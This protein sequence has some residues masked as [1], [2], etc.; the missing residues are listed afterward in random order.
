MLKSFVFRVSLT[1]GLILLGA[2]G[3]SAQ[4]KKP[5][6]P[7]EKPAVAHTK[8]AGNAG[9]HGP[10]SPGKPAAGTTA[11]HS[12]ASAGGTHTGPTTN[13]T[14]THTGTTT[15]R[16]AA[17]GP[18]TA[19][20]S[21]TANRPAAGANTN[22]G[23]P[24]SGSTV[25][26][27]PGS[28]GRP[29]GPVHN[30]AVRPASYG[31]AGRPAPLGSHQQQLRNGNALQRRPNGRISDVHDARRGMEI[32]NSLNGG[33]R[34]VVERPDHSR[35]FAERGRPGYIQRPY[36]YQGHDF[37]RRSYYYHGH[38]YESYYR[39]YSYRG[40]V[41][42]VYAPVRYYPIGFY[43][44]A[45]HPWRAPIVFAWGWGG[46]PWYG[47]YGGYFAPYP[48]YATPAL[49]LT[50]YMISSELAAAYEAGRESAASSAP[51]PTA[52]TA[53]ALT[54]EV[55]QQIAVE[56]QSQIALE[57]AEAQQTANHQD[58]DPASS[59]IARMLGDGHTHVFVAGG[60]LDVVDASGAECALTDG[61]VLQLVTPPPPDATSAS[62][63]VLASKGNSECAKSTTVTVALADLQDMQ[64]HMRETID[65]GMEE[66]RQKQGS[67]GLPAA[68]PS[69][70]AAPTTAPFAQIAP[71][72]DP[73]DAKTIDQQMNA[74]DQAEQEVTAQAGQ[75]ANT[76]AP[77]AGGTSASH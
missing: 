52:N 3:L 62:L 34:V 10:A 41:I 57:N 55:K 16:P 26:H 75:E 20:S 73:N 17:N 32:H 11:P 25:V 44:W 74:A 60:P 47:Y 13:G 40:V 68:P 35:V 51:P 39:G 2:V 77:A 33:R 50:D 28:M 49:W 7:A 1:T 56:V 59:G 70:V 58:V 48:V 29:G 38:M 36:V 64:N 9:A 14:A 37:A 61:D 6:K 19:H 53:P 71:P 5:E 42:N 22:A 27:Q 30:P 65:R 31:I 67:G 15:T 4:D 76:P 18:S 69:A 54:P 12:G 8:P 46:A 21:V 24:G 72:P 63:V 43:G 66:L 45:Y 23:R